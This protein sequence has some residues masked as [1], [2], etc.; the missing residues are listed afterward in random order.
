MEAFGRRF[1]VLDKDMLIR[2]KLA[3]DRDKDR[4]DVAELGEI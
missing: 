2:S 3:A 4:Q 1:P